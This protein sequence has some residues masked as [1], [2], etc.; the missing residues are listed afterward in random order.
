MAVKKFQNF[1]NRMEKMEETFN[2][3]YGNLEEMKNKQQ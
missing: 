3:F 1:E 2:I